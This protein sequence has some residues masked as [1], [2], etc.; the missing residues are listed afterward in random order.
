MTAN[1]HNTGA[2]SIMIC[3]L[4]AVTMVTLYMCDMI[5]RSLLPCSTQSRIIHRVHHI[6]AGLH[7]INILI[8]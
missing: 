4:H 8:P 2:L 1:M 3:N 5:Y 7:V 6:H